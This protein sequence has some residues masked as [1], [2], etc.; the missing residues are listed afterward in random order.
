MIKWV[1]A[2]LSSCLILISSHRLFQLLGWG[3]IGGSKQGILEEHDFRPYSPYG[4]KELMTHRLYRLSWAQVSSITS[5]N[6]SFSFKKN[7]G[8]MTCNVIVFFK[9]HCHFRGWAIIF[10]G[11]WGTMSKYITKISSSREAFEQNNDS[12][13]SV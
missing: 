6:D 10:C 11:E 4:E 2:L 9:S 5:I 12:S 13:V 7:P 3:R 8:P 1:G